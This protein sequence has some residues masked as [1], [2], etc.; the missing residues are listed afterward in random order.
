M[1]HNQSENYKAMPL[2]SWDIYIDNYHKQ[3]VEAK[4]E[5]ELQQVTMLAE[6]YKWQND[7]RTVFSK[8]EYEALIITDINQNIIWVNEGFT[9]MTGYSQKFAINRTPRF[10][11]GMQTSQSTKSR[12]RNKIKQ[13][14][15]FK[16][17]IVN[18]KKDKTTYKCEVNIIPLYGKETTH[19]IAFEK[20]VV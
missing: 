8:R 7:L 17:I 20:Q 4:K 5:L 13:Q 2:T 12:I 10:L 14:Q 1:L 6:K 11:Q 15:P 19:F 9:A 18:H 16:E 3:L